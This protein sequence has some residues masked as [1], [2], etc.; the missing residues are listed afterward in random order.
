MLTSSNQYIRPEYLSPLPTTF[1]SKSSPLALLA[2]TCSA[3]GSDSPNPKLLANIEKSTKSNRDKLSP[4][5]LSSGSSNDT[6]KSSFKPYE[7]SAITREQTR[8]PDDNRNVSA[9]HKSP[10]RSINPP[11]HQPQNGRCESNQSAASSRASPSNHNRRTPGGS[12][13]Q[14]E[15]T[16][17]PNRASAKDSPNTL[18]NSSAEPITSKGPMETTSKDLSNS[19]ESSVRASSSAPSSTTVGPP[20]Y[21]SY[22]SYPMDLMT[23]SALMSPHHQMLK[24]AAMNPYFNYAKLKIPGAVDSMIPVCR[25]PY[26]TGCALSS[27]MLGKLGS[28]G[29]PAGC[30]QCDHP[31]S[32]SYSQAAAAASLAASQSSAAMYAHAQLAALAAASQLPY[33]CNWIG[34][35]SSYCGKRFAASEELFQHLRT[36]H[37]AGVSMSEALLNP[38]TAAAAAAGLPPTHPLFQ[39]TYPT[40]PL[41]PMSTARYHPYGKPPLLPP[42]MSPASLAGIPMPPHPSL[43]QYFPPYSFYGAR[44]NGSN[45]MHP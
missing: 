29:C 39:R 5:T 7:P 37:A 14:Q 16:N 23:A 1:D 33:V 9:R 15:R 11:N 40:P 2:Q 45:N 35:D 41:S 26:C 17:S 10:K 34:S 28:S 20:Y 43:A 25:D 27:H 4:G 3:I 42:A 21:S 36:Q 24:A 32:K 44:L 30:T 8:S 18:P 31:G 22:G 6:P 19:S 12:Q 13:L 38:A